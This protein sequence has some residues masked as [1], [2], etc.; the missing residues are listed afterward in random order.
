MDAATDRLTSFHNLNQTIDYSSDSEPQIREKGSSRK[1]ARQPSV[2][3]SEADEDEI[4]QP[5]L[6][7]RVEQL[8]LFSHDDAG[9]AVDMSIDAS[10]SPMNL[11]RSTTPVPGGGNDFMDID[12]PRGV[13]SSPGVN[14]NPFLMVPSPLRQDYMGQLLLS[15]DEDES[16]RRFDGDLQFDPHELENVKKRSRAS[17]EG[18]HAPDTLK[19]AKNNDGPPQTGRPT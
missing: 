13:G 6:S 14:V 16:I 10:Y 18:I 2:V 3:V 12:T 19:K 5:N 1:L 17:S 9:G 7:S 4:S 15:D 8:Q 11:S